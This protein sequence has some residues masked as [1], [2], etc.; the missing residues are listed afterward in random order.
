MSSLCF[1]TDCPDA[2][3]YFQDTTIGGKALASSD[4]FDISLI[5][6]G[7]KKPGQRFAVFILVSQLSAAFMIY[8]D[9]LTIPCAYQLAVRLSGWYMRAS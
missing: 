1:T 8:A 2:I 3:I 9:E 7:S 6:T 5:L 4:D